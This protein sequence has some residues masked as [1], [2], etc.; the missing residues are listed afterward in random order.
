M[1]KPVNGFRAAFTLIELLVVIAI[2]AI[3][4]AILFPVFARARENARKSSCQ[5]NL[6]QIGLGFAQYTQDYDERY[7]HSA[8]NP[9]PL[10]GGWV[11]GGNN[12]FSFPTDVSQGALYPYLKSKQI[13][14]CPSDTNATTKQLSYSM[15]QNVSQKSLAE[16]DQPAQTMLLIDEGE[17]LNDGNFNALACGLAGGLDKPTIIHLEGFNAAF[18]DGHVKWR[19][20]DTLVKNDF[21]YRSSDC[22]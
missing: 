22:P 3:L 2:I 15:N 6:K 11:L 10:L 4:A 12:A 7:P 5:S 14:I 8:E 9:Q 20:P 1:Q 21:R 18:T 17:T 13:F 19:R 16:N